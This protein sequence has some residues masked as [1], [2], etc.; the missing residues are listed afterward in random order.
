MS[1]EYYVE[2]D[3]WYVSV[4]STLYASKVLKKIKNL[5]I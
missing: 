4:N 5:K 2:H 1:S 3:P